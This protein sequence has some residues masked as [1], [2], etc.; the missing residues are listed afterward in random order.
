M[1]KEKPMIRSKVSALLLI[2][3]FVCVIPALAQ[4]APPEKSA[5]AITGG[6]AIP[7][8]SARVESAPRKLSEQSKETVSVAENAEPQDRPLSAPANIGAKA[9]APAGIMETEWKY[10]K[11]YGDDKDEDVAAAML[12]QLTDWLRLYSDSEYADEAQLLKARLHLRLGDYKSAIVDLLK[13]TQEYP[14]SKFNADVKKLLNETIDKKMD[15]KTKPV[16]IEIAASPETADKSQRLALFLEKLS[17]KAGDTF[18]GP[19]VAEFREF[20]NRFPLY[21]GRD[22]LQLVLGNLHSKKEEYLSARLA[23]ERLIQV[24]PDSK[25]RVRAKKLLGDVLANN[26]KDYN[27]AIKIY[28][29]ITADSPGTGEAWASYKQLARLS[30]RQKQY[31]LAVEI[32]ERI[33]ALYPDEKMEVYNAFISEA[34]ILREEL[35]KPKEAVEVLN[36]L[37]AQYKGAKA[38]EALY[39][40]AEIARKDMKDLDTEIQMYD[41]IAA[42]Y[43]AEAPKALFAAGQACEK[44]KSFDKARE[45]YDT[46][47]QK[48]P[49]DSLVAK[50]QKYRTAI[51]FK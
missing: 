47:V 32:Y 26:I 51:E 1:C 19:A 10:L 4:D 36:R 42:D 7:L 33:I 35:S 48:Y 49:D 3:P 11:A 23:Y 5:D 15:K 34:R 31:P 9:A 2:L 41:K 44:N 21:A 12:V 45:Y 8:T 13:H 25:F 20:F 30:E 28:Q 27:A 40:A 29:G 43:Q 24:Y 50:A 16:L 14:N 37:A 6:N 38:I 46:V 39:L 22:G 17:D 18:Y